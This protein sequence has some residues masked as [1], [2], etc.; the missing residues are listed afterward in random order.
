VTYW[1][2]IFSKDSYFDTLLQ[3]FCYCIENKGLRLHDF[4]FM[5]NHFHAICSCGVGNLADVIGDIKGFTSKRIAALLKSDGRS[6]WLYALKRAGGDE[7]DV[8]VWQDGFHPEQIHSLPFYEQK[9]RYLY[10]NP[11]RA[12]YVEDILEWR[13][14]SARYWYADGES[15]LPLEAIDW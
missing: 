11:V 7:I 13:H 15:L 4:V 6:K 3:S 5:P 1:L 14:S 2:P 8:K 12:G 9:R 10:E